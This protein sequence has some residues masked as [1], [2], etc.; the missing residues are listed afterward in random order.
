MT[1]EEYR[2]AAHYWTER[3]Y[4]AMPEEKLKSVV[5]E[6][7][8]EK[9]VC[10]LATGY[11]GFVRCTP[12]EYSFHDGLFWIFTEGGEK[13][14]GLGE[15]SFVSI[16]VFDGNPD[17]GG[18]RSVQVAGKATLIEPMSETYIAHAAYKRISAAVLEDLLEKGHPM[19]LIAV[20]PL[21]MD[22]L[23]S[24]FRKLGYDSRQVLC[25]SEEYPGRD[26]E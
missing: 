26:D 13:F 24:D 7:L 6:F 10:A 3:E 22:V 1:R 17:F 23:F 14:T 15:N 19:Y 25:F 9:C 12:L 4:K 11:G 20:R 8:S 2:K 18:L 5:L 21:K 16:A